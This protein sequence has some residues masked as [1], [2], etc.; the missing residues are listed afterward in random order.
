MGCI[1]LSSIMIPDS[2]TEIGEYA[3]QWCT[4]LPSIMIPDSVTKISGYAFKGCTSLKRI[5]T[6]RKIFTRFRDCF[7]KNILLQ[8]I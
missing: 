2:V 1:S 4:S 7:Y 3:F 6:T 5:I 8:E